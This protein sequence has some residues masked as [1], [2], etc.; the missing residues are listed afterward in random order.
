MTHVSKHISALN[1]EGM[2]P[3]IHLL[4]REKYL[5]YCSTTVLYGDEL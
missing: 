2:D 3:F 1:S 4:W 5:V